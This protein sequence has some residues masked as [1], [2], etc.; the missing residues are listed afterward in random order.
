MRVWFWIPSIYQAFS[1]RVKIYR[2][3]EDSPLEKGFKGLLFIRNSKTF[4]FPKTSDS[5]KSF[6]T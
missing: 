5:N 4:N 2:L 3:D 6:D 1:L